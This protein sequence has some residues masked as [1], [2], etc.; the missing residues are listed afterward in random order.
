MTLTTKQKMMET[1]R[2]LRIFEKKQNKTK[3]S[4]KT[5]A[6]SQGLDMRVRKK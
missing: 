5:D 6:Q 2:S 3:Q 1:I 4:T